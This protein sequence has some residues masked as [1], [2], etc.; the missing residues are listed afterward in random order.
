MVDTLRKLPSEQAKVDQLLQNERV[1]KFCTSCRPGHPFLNALGG[2]D[3]ASTYLL[4][5]L[6]AIG[7]DHIFDIPADQHGC[8]ERLAALCTNLHH[9][10]SFYDSIGGLPGYQLKCLETM[11]ASAEVPQ[12]C[13]TEQDTP[14]DTK[15]YMPQGLD[16]AGHHNR[17]AA[18][19]AAATGLEAL[20]YMAEILPLGGAGDRL[21]LQCDVT[22][23]SVPTAMLPYCGR[24]LLSGIIRDLQ[25]REYLYY[26]VFGSQETTPIAIMTSA[27]KGNHQRVQK[28]LADS[29][30]FGRGKE[31]C[32]LFEQP[33]VPVVSTEDGS[34]LLP[35]PLRPLM[36]PGG[37]GAIWKLMLD[38]GI[39]TWLRNR[40]REAAIVRQISNPLA[41]TD[42]TLLA[43]SGAGYADGK[44]FGF[45]SC[46]RRAGA[47]EGVNVLMERRLKRVDGDGYEYAYNVTNVEYTE[48]DR[49]G[50]PDEC[51]DGS[52]YSRYPANTNVLYIGLQAVEAA[53]KAGV[54]S[55]G[56][57]ALPGMIFNQ[58][59]KVA[60]TD[61]VSGED[62]SVYAG[63]L[64]CTM[65]NVVDSLAQR[66]NEPM[67]ES[68]HGSLNTFVVYNQRRCVTSSAK[69]RRKPG[70][71]MVSQTPDGS[72][73]DLMRN[74]ADLLTRCG[75]SHVPEVGSVEEY[76]EKGPGFIFLYHPAL[77]P[78]WDVIAQKIRGGALMHGSELVLEVADAALMDVRV[79]GSLLVHADCVTGS[80][81]SPH[82]AGTQGH[83]F[84]TD[85]QVSHPDGRQTLYSTEPASPQLAQCDA[86]AP[87][88]LHLAG[89]GSEA[90]TAGHSTSSVV[91]FPRAGNPENQRLVFSD[92]CGRVRL[93]GVVV[94]NKGI[95]W[96]SPS[97]C[98]WQHKV[99]RKEAA[100]IVLHGQSEFEASHVVLE[101]DH[102]FEVPDGYRMVVSAAPA[103]GLRRA[104]FP[105]HKRRPSWQWDYQMDA[106]GSIKLS[107]L[108]TARPPTYAPALLGTSA[109][110]PFVYVI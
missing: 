48:F 107:I 4:L 3:S 72:F 37:H 70:S 2:L 32:R 55:G 82:A 13:A 63:R 80:M 84:A 31:S 78:L 41:G 22:G 61:V 45:A 101:G 23:E 15:F 88:Q 71:T 24:S 109:E 34:W 29:N 93:T 77:G 79:D 58:G 10:D 91:P 104:L 42:A 6:V 67:P 89:A 97:N 54:K 8:D 51:L 85:I 1:V 98:Y 30:W 103:G 76:L 81:E 33:M 47:A 26:K 35:E 12:A 18:A 28:L 94:R 56:G 27:A 43:L 87:M 65:Q 17:R 50:V 105:L 11:A 102:T 7:Q 36:K 92:R 99:A 86:G 60:Y 74:A 96:A 40:R 90:A 19:V 69:R 20:P 49:L 100:R 25:A 108:E 62:K 59:K 75:L 5:C 44:C 52:Q 57:A 21:G 39:F 110:A 9:V 38:E 53:V 64:E 14:S 68:L 83:S 16:I 95:D 46:E 66:F 73:L 106:Q